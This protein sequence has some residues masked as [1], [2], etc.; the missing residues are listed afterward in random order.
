MKKKKRETIACHKVYL[1]DKVCSRRMVS[2]ARGIVSI[3][4]GMISAKL[5]ELDMIPSH[6]HVHKRKTNKT[7]TR[8]HF[9][10]EDYSGTPMTDAATVFC[11]VFY[12]SIELRWKTV[13][14]FQRYGCTLYVKFH[15]R[16]TY[17]RT[18]HNVINIIAVL[19]YYQCARR[20]S[21]KWALSSK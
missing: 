2:A 1:G 7:Y 14:H 12:E 18:C 5:F 4:V 3:Q 20:Q 11:R 6:T 21:Q 15:S 16:H 19:N 10:R 17:N 13:F 8:T 9:H